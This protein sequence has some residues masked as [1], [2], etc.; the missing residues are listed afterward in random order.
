MDNNNNRSNRYQ[1]DNGSLSNENDNR[2]NW[3]RNYTPGSNEWSEKNEKPN[4]FSSD[5][6]RDYWNAKNY[7]INNRMEDRYWNRDSYNYSGNSRYPSDYPTQ[8]NRYSNE[9]DHF[10]NNYSYASDN[11]NDSNR[12]FNNQ[13]NNYGS[14]SNNYRN[15]R[16]RRHQDIDFNR[17]YQ[18]EGW[19]DNY[20]D[21]DRNWWDKT[22]DEV[23]SWFGDDNAERR[24]NRDEMKNGMHRGKGPKNYTRSEDRIRE[25]VSDQ[26]SEDSYLDASNIEVEV[27]GSEVTLNGTVDS[28][29]SKHRAE[30]LTED[31][32]GVTHVQNNL[33]VVNEKTPQESVANQ[34]ANT[35]K[36]TNEYLNATENY[37]KNKKESSLA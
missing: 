29:Y 32:T 16:D 19:Q 8:Q 20:R 25:D 4:V 7:P 18:K 14:E 23:A 27:K 17:N 30:D 10:R 5:R 28:R 9:P 11:N 21:S 26:L 33:R 36:K 24:R 34:N 37:Q 13:Y 12:H 35:V 3:D 15:S 22:R 2:M 1:D 31:V 6:E